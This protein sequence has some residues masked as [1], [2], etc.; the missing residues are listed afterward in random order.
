MMKVICANWNWQQTLSW[1]LLQRKRIE[2]ELQDYRL[3]LEELVE[4]RTAELLKAKQA[5]ESANI[6]KSTFIATMSHELRTPLNAILGFSELMTR[7][8]SIT[9]TQ[10]DTLNI[11]NRSGTHL[12]NMINDVLEISKIEAGHSELAV[13]ACDLPNLLWDIG[14]MISGR[15]ADK[16]L[17]FT[18]EIDSDIT[19]CV[20][21]D[22]GKLQQVLINLLGNA[23]KFTQQGGVILRARTYPLSGTEAML[24]ITVID[25][26]Y[27]MTEEQQTKLFKPFVQLVPAQ[28]NVSG[29][30]LG[31][32]ISKSLIELMGGHISVSSTVGTGSTFKVELP[33]AIAHKNTI[34]AIEECQPVKG[35]MPD[36]PTWRLL[37]VDDNADNRLLLSTMLTAVGFQVR[38]AENGQ[39]AI[40][41]FEQ[42][43]PHLIWMDMRMPVLD[44]YEAATRIRQLP[45]GD[46]VKI[47]AITASAFKEQ[48][49]SIIDAGCDAVIHKPFR[50]SEV[51]AALTKMLTVKFV[52]EDMPH[53]SPFL[54]VT[55]E[56]LDTL[57][58]T[59][60]QQLHNAAQYLDIYP[61]NLK[62][63]C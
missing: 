61:I 25:S 62:I 14:N 29:T 45:G 15:A 20:A 59:L 56:M 51:F 27:G 26:G 31:L 63:L 55:A 60:R 36:Q 40:H 11:I 1:S 32:A 3:H 4:T 24:I 44:G 6:A 57:P 17:N 12:L 22:N 41:L 38:E 10:K 35:I 2:L 48:H 46:S 13:Q 47:I 58:I 5:A 19:Q 42:W 28:A 7:D 21:I 8:N 43:Q 18:V 16:Q 50:A 53:V 30:G 54:G 49:H 9:A 23:I 37:I 33:V 34:T 52:Y 39:Q